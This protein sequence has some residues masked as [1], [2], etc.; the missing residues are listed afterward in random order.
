[1]TETPDVKHGS[2]VERETAENLDVAAERLA[3]AIALLLPK[4]ILRE[5]EK[6]ISCEQPPEEQAP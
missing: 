6:E 5:L 3:V 4:I 1:M 2:D